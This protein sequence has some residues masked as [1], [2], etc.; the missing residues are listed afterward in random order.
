MLA[1]AVLITLASPL[2]AGQPYQAL[3]AGDVF[4]ATITRVED[5]EATNSRPPRVWLNVHE[6]IRG[7]PKTV[8]S[9]AVWSPPFH[10][11]DWGDG[12]Q[13][14][15]KLWRAQPL[16]GPKVGE[17]FILGG[18]ALGVPPDEK[19]A[20]AYNLFDFVRIPY[21]DAARAR[22]IAHLAVLDAARRKYAEEQAAAD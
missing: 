15:L 8:R 6:V 22:T 21:S 17:K 4:V 20:P 13:P 19:D 9:P 2:R 16:K 14:E 10:G 1:A 18:R 11:I 7:N 3:D 12:N 5:K